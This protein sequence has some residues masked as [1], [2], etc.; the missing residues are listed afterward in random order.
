MGC[1]TKIVM[2]KFVLKKRDKKDKVLFSKVVSDLDEIMDIEEDIFK[3]EIIFKEGIKLNALN[4]LDEI[5][6]D[7]IQTINIIIF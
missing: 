2:M 7:K 3:F 5:E 1:N 6:P 4:N